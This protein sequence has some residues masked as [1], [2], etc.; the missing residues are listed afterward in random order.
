MYE[1]CVRKLV[2]VGESSERLFERG[3][4]VYERPL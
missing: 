2:R 3:R 1:M 4:Y